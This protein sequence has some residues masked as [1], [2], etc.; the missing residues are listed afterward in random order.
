MPP[1][2]YKIATTIFIISAKAPFNNHGFAHGFPSN[3]KLYCRKLSACLLILLAMKSNTSQVCLWGHGGTI[4]AWSNLHG[5]METATIQ[6][7]SKYVHVHLHM[8][9]LGS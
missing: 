9:V 3:E 8:V 7:M 5:R 1:L 4:L 6:T 2:H